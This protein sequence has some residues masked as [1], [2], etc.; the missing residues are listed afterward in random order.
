MSSERVLL[1]KDVMNRNVRAI[2]ADMGARDAVSWLVQHAYSGAP[3]VDEA[4]RLLGVFTEHDCIRALADSLNASM[5]AGNV[6][7]YMTK[8]LLS[9]APDTPVLDV[10]REFTEGKHRRLLVIDR[11]QLVGIITRRDLVRGLS[12][13]LEPTKHFG[14]YSVLERMWR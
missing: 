5:P 2:K 13:L 4:G 12:S 7:Y 14:T 10:A 1:A 9:I 11:G 8:A 6:S 3:V